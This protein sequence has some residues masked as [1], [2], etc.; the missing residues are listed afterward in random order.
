MFRPL[1]FFTHYKI[2]AHYKFF[3]S[4][5]SPTRLA[6]ARETTEATDRARAGL[7]TLLLATAVYFTGAPVAFALHPTE[8]SDLMAV[9][10]AGAIM[11][12]KSTWFEPKLADGIASHMLD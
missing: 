10:D 6:A 2:F 8:M 12:P 9:A 4:C 7:M 1:Q 3:Y 5:A 11:P